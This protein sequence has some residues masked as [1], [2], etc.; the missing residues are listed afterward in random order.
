MITGIVKSQVRSLSSEISDPGSVLFSLEEELSRIRIGSFLT[1]MLVF[2]RPAEG[3]VLYAGAGHPPILALTPGGSVVELP[4]TG[5]PLNTGLGVVPRE[6]SSTARRAGLR[7][8][9]HTDGYGEAAD[10]KGR[11]FDEP[12]EEGG[13]AFDRAVLE[14][15]SADSAE[16]GLKRLESAWTHFVP[17]GRGEDDRAAVL[18]R[19]L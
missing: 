1:A 10:G 9:L 14:A 7:L 6:T 13:S 18:A 19:L 11:H 15:L 16:E 12:E 5:I 4:S 8:L 3:E 17:G 2:D